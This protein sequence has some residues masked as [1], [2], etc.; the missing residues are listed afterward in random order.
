M[1]PTCR[2]RLSDDAGGCGL[3]IGEPYC[4]HGLFLGAFVPLGILAY[5]GTAGHPATTLSDGAKLL[6]GLLCYHGG[7]TGEFPTAKTLAGEMGASERSV[8][9][10]AG[11]LSAHIFIRVIPGHRGHHNRYIFL[12]HE[13][14]ASGLRKTPTS[15]DS[16]GTERSPD[17]ATNDAEKI[18]NSGVLHAGKVASSGE[19]GRQFLSERSPDLATAYKEEENYKEN[20]Q[21]KKRT[22]SESDPSLLVDQD[23][24]TPGSVPRGIDLVLD[25]IAKAIYDRHPQRRRDCV[26][27]AVRKSLVAILR[28]KKVPR[29][30]Q[31]D[32]L[33][34]I[35]QNHTGWCQSG[36]WTK[37]DGE[38]AKGLSNW[39]APTMD[40]YEV[41]APSNLPPRKTTAKLNAEGWDRAYPNDEPRSTV[42]HGTKY[43]NPDTEY[44][45]EVFECLPDKSNREA[46]KSKWR[47]F[48]MDRDQQRK[49]IA[50]I[51][52]Y[53]ASR[54]VA[55]GKIKGAVK[56]LEE[57]FANDWAG[58]WG[59]GK[60]SIDEMA[61]N[62]RSF[63]EG[64][65]TR[66]DA[67]NEALKDL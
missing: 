9:R 44:F 13:C 40:R 12:W 57:Q 32:Y 49:A 7:R 10:Y 61:N 36:G 26:V 6:F 41:Q 58:E 30:D 37:D 24:S 65:Q 27:R 53:A 60:P 33:L 64:R 34:Q 20:K 11:E 38:F 29:A 56:L 35:D 43:L 19:K 8:S 39:L 67:I 1:G 15:S 45:D 25:E 3:T 50:C 28:N 5:R 66:T 46:A 22:S 55:E 2:P 14:L 16:G 59:R 47:S 4:P 54:E 51:K 62:L 17:L 23:E 21:E 31:A 52:R 48:E 63:R 18:A 42:R